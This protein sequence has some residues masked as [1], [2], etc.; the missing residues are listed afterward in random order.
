VMD[1]RCVDL[2]AADVDADDG[3]PG[4]AATIRRR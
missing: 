4:H 3:G 1:E 2:R